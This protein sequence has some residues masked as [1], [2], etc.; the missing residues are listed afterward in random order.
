MTRCSIFIA[1]STAT[2][3]PGRTTSPSRTV[4]RDDRALHRRARRPP[5]LRADLRACA[6]AALRSPLRSA[7]GKVQRLGRASRAALDAA[8]RCVRRRSACDAVAAAKSGCASSACRN[9]MLVATPSMRN[10]RKRA[11]GLR[12]RR[13]PAR[14]PARA[15]SPWRAASRSRIG[16][17]ARIAEGVDAHARPGRRLERGERAAGRLRRA[18]GVHRLHVDA[19][20][21]RVAARLRRSRLASGRARPASCRAASCELRLRRGRRRSPPRSRCARPAGAGWPR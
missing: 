20:L 14:Q 21:D 8:R 4:D 18:V 6:A 5:C 10:S 15:R 17:V 2:C 19:Q 16:R 9:A 13:R 1:S 7:R 11:R 12:A 3:W